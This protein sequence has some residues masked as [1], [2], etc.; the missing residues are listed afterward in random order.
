MVMGQDFFRGKMGTNVEVPELTKLLDMQLL[1]LQLLFVMPPCVLQDAD[2]QP[3]PALV[4]TGIFA[5]D[6]NTALGS[7]QLLFMNTS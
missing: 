6:W 4:G 2:I 5:L 7:C 3:R 1:C